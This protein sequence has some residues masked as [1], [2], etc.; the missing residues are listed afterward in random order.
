MVFDPL[1]YVE[2]VMKLSYTWLADKPKEIIFDPL[3][4][5]HHVKRKRRFDPL[6]EHLENC[7]DPLSNM[8]FSKILKW[9]KITF[10][11]QWR[12]I[13]VSF[14][15]SSW[16]YFRWGILKWIKI[17]SSDS[18]VNSSNITRLL[19]SKKWF[20][21]CS[22]FCSIYLQ[23]FE[24]VVSTRVNNFFWKFLTKTFLTTNHCINMGRW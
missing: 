24:L 19:I 18:H 14:L 15:M 9:I 17:T 7:F 4:V 21:N 20:K 6:F 8:N 12:W 1:W 23:D 11:L 3:Q 16:W 10:R 2:E 5:F 13:K 22:V